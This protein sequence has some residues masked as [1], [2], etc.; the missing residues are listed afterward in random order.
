MRVAPPS[1]ESTVDRQG[2]G[3][4]TPGPRARLARWHALMTQEP[5]LLPPRILRPNGGLPSG[6]SKANSVVAQ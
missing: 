6:R 4:R 3:Q 2:D 5:T 1:G